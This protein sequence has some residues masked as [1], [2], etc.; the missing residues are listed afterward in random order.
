MNDQETGKIPIKYLNRIGDLYGFD[1]DILSYVGGFENRVYSFS[2]NNQEY[3]LRIGDSKHMAFD[4]VKA[5]IDWVVYLAGNNIPVV[6]P[7]LSENG[8]YIEK[9]EIDDGYLNVVLFEKA[10]G[11][12]LDHR[13]PQN[14]SDELIMEYGRTTGKMH[15]LSKSYEVNE[16]KR[17]E[18]KPALDIEYLLKNEDK[19]TISIISNHFQEIEK[20]PKDKEGYGLVHGDLHTGNFFVQDDKITALLD[21][22]RTCYKWFISEIAVALYYPLYLTHLKENKEEQKKFVKRFLPLYMKGYETENKLD[23]L[24]MEK[25]D[26]FIKVRDAI[27]F[28][29]F[30]PGRNGFK[31]EV[32]QRITEDSYLD[33]QEIL[34]SM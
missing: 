34:K 31:K 10:K 2:K 33:I 20:L 14:W 32:K 5:E 17:Y 16:S 18:F 7:V 24:W 21:F 8:N 6:K 23:S 12:H 1:P 28:M 27:L 19:R 30:P 22:D 4:L 11:E 26:I 9:V 29:Y 25:I 15:A 13:N 3:F